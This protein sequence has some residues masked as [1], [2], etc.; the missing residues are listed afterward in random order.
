MGAVTSRFDLVGHALIL[1]TIGFTV[2]G[3]LILKQQMS[4]LPPLPS[5]AAMFPELLKLILTRPLIFSGLASAFIASLF[6]MGAIQRFPLSYA[7]PFMSLTY[8]LVFGLAFFLFGD[9]MN[10]AK[11]FGLAMICGGVALIARGG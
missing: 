10:P 8:V 2:Y 6:W 11:I 1:G 9:A 5:G 3:Q 4:G 7:Y